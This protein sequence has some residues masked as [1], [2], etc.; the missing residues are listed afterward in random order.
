MRTNLAAISHHS[1]LQLK[2]INPRL[3]FSLSWLTLERDLEQT[4]CS[5]CFTMPSMQGYQALGLQ[6][7]GCSAQKE[8]PLKKFS[9]QDIQGSQEVIPNFSFKRSDMVQILNDICAYCKNLSLCFTERSPA[10]IQQGLATTLI[11]CD[12]ILMS[13]L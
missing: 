3:Q 4:F 8:N 5:Q 6:D 13:I 12:S 9:K 7:G 10:K 2:K 11:N 1:G